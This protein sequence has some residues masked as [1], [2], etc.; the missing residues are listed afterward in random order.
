M[1]GWL[2]I[3]GLGPG[4]DALIT[5]EVDHALSAATDIIG[6]FPYVARVQKRPGLTLH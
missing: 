4:N 1:S 3:V 5:P 2:K 6:Y